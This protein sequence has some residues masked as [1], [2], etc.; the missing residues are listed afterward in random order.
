M[1]QIE[2]NDED[3]QAIKQVIDSSNDNVTAAELIHQLVGMIDL[4]QR[5]NALEGK[6]AGAI[7]YAS[8]AN[9]TSEAVLQDLHRT[10]DQLEKKIDDLALTTKATAEVVSES[11]EADGLLDIVF[12]TEA[13]VWEEAVNTVKQRKETEDNEQ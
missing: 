11:A 5:L 13:S 1:T 4:D 3:Y 6:I 8:Y 10:S 2:I 9:K 7:K 12:G